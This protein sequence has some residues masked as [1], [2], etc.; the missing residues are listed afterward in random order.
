M[1]QVV[2]G[3]V[4]K[5]AIEEIRDRTIVGKYTVEILILWSNPPQLSGVSCT[6]SLIGSLIQLI[7]IGSIHVT[8]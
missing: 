7:E 1:R 3:L 4:G 6:Y 5:I 2:S 8:L